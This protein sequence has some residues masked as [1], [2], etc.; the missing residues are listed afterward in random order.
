MKKILIISHRD[1]DGITSAV[2]Y[3]WNYLEENNFSK[4]IKNIYKYSDIID[5]DHYDNIDQIFKKKKINLKNYSQLIILDLSFSFEKILFFY[6][7][8]K[9]NFIWIDHHKRQD[10][11]IEKKLKSKK[12][13]INGIRNSKYSACVHVWKYFKKGTPDFVKYIDDIDSW[14]LKIKDSKEFIASLDNVNERYTK[15]NIS[16][17]LKM[18][19]FDYFSKVKQEIINKGK[20]ILQ[21]Q[22]RHVNEQL[23]YGRIINFHG[24]K[25]F[26]INTNFSPTFFSE[27]FFNLKDKK[28]KNIDILIIWY[29]IY[30]S[31]EFKFSLRKREN[32]KI[33]LS[34]IAKEYGGAGHYGAAGF[35]LK[36]LADLKYTDR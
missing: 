8:F 11:E 31:S 13:K 35:F 36:S 24:H 26:I 15:K 10:Q 29:K 34:K 7:I 18:L 19:S 27:T 22:K 17:I 21:H 25:S 28:Y 30:K 9:E 14:K 32:V 12:I 23:I 4:N 1:A 5:Y 16:F 6:N 2:S 20:I 33:D 3:V